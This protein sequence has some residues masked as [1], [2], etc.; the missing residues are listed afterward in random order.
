MQQMKVIDVSDNQGKIDWQ[1]VAAAGVK[2]AILRSVKRSGQPDPTFYQNLDGC[3]KNGIR[4][5]VYKY[6][7]AQN[8]TQAAE[9]AQ[10]VA[11]LLQQAGLKCPVW[12]DVEDRELLVP[13]GRSVLTACIQAAQEAVEAAGYEFGIYT[14]LDFYNSGYFDTDHFDCPYWIA[15]YPSGAVME[16]GQEPDESKK[17]QI[18]GKLRGWQYTSNGRVEGISGPVDLSEFYVESCKYGL[19]AFLKAILR[20]LLELLHKI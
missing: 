6:T 17:P 15:R 16:L 19:L 7:Y 5:E 8:Q 3:R 11:A 20:Q 9:E 14:G 1:E 4:T 10:Q 18:K 2:K 12:W 13:L